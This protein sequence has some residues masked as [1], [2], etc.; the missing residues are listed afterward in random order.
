MNTLSL[1]NQLFFMG[2]EVWL[3]IAA[4]TLLVLGAFLGHRWTSLISY[5]SVLSLGAAAAYA[6]GMVGHPKVELFNKAVVVDHFAVFSKILILGTAALALVLGDRWMKRVGMQK[7]EYAILILLATL[8]MM[9]MVSAN[10]LISLYLGI[11]M[12]S[13]AL[14]VLAAFSRNNGKSSEAGLKYFVLGALSSGLLL[15]GIS[16][17]YGFTGHVNFD[18]IANALP[19]SHKGGVVFGLVFLLAGLAFKVSAAPFHMWTPD[20][21][22]GAP[23]PVVAFF[24]SAPKLAAMVLIARVLLESFALAVHEWQQI[25]IVIAVLSMIIGAFG[26]LVQTNIKRLLAYSSIA[27]MGFALVGLAA[28]T[29]AGVQGTLIYMVLYMITSVGLFAGLLLTARAGHALETFDDFK[30]FA[31]VQ[32]GFAIVMTMLLF[33]T[34]GIPPLAGFWG[35][36]FV[37]K[38]AVSAGLVWLAV[39][40]VVLSVIGAFYY[41]KLIKVMWFDDSAGE[42]DGIAWD[43]GFIATLIALL[44]G[45]IS[46]FALPMLEPWA[47][48]AAAVLF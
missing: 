10:S 21:Y 4:M 1:T 34:A 44:V 36:F 28:G 26:G 42:V 11:E 22:E 46:W 31:K 13:L 12:Q 14:Y 7:F 19:T 29:A 40:G 2:V 15:Y 30:G 17:I 45:P 8:G 5:L 33:S 48:Q 41:L 35:K 3:A 38:A 47:K 9:V 23:T 16:L 37:F 32:P 39:I 25:L 6:L 18:Q 20:V 27:N 24:S 43:A